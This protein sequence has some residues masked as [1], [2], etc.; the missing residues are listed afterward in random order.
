M[1]PRPSANH[2]V[3]IC[4]HDLLILMEDAKPLPSLEDVLWIGKSIR[5]LLV[6]GT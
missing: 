2:V 3:A 1:S 4:W 5:D 6:N